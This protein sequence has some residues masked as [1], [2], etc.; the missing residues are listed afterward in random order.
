M[1]FVWLDEYS[2]GAASLMPPPH[3]QQA[4]IAESPFFTKALSVCSSD[5]WPGE[6]N[7][8][9]DKSRQEFPLRSV[10]SSTS[11][12]GTH[13]GPSEAPEGMKPVSH[14]VQR[15]K[16]AEYVAQPEQ[17]QLLA[18]QHCSKT[19]PD[20]KRCSLLSP[21]AHFKEWPDA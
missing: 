5:S 8:F 3:A 16:V 10:H 21:I 13:W 1:K 9:E 2:N 6:H 7:P 17:A 15:S 14:A 11:W 19:C 18:G 4:V 20:S 12:H